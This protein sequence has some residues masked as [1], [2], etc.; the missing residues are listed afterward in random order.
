M[1]REKSDTRLRGSFSRRRRLH[2]HR[3]PRKSPATQANISD[4]N[5]RVVS[6]G[7]SRDVFL[8]N[9]TDQHDD[10]VML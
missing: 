4:L 8:L 9:K 7:H 2:F 10:K 6:S 5:V 1:E 3:A